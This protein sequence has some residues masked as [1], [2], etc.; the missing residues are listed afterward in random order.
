MLSAKAVIRSFV[1]MLHCQQT[2]PTNQPVH[3]GIGARPL[4]VISDDPYPY[5]PSSSSNHPVFTFTG[6]SFSAS[7]IMGNRPQEHQSRQSRYPKVR[8]KSKS[9]GASP[10]KYP[11]P[12]EFNEEFINI[13][14]SSDSID[15]GDSCD[16]FCPVMCSSSRSSNASGRS[17]L[18]QQYVQRYGSNSKLLQV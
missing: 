10:Q 18:S 11:S 2:S 16:L 6:S 3:P 5:F 12:V 7:N 17:Y 13:I 8:Q 15:Y 4:H 14:T 1:K 9:S